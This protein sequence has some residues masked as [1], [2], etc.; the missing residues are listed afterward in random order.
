[1]KQICTECPERCILTEK[2]RNCP[3]LNSKIWLDRSAIIC[4]TCPNIEEE[5]SR[6]TREPVPRDEVG[7]KEE[8]QVVSERLWA[9]YK[10]RH[11]A[12]KQY[13]DK[14]LKISELAL[15]TQEL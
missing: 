2:I 10:L 7:K 6:C 4:R 8:W 3:Q 14:T 1:M 15:A 12:W 5:C 11:P 9:D 13:L